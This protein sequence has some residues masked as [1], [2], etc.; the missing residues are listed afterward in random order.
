MRVAVWGTGNMGRAAVRA[1]EAHPELELAGV[2]SRSQPG[3]ADV[4]EGVDAVA[5]M[6]SGDLRPDEAAADIAGCLRGGAVVV[7]PSLYALY[8]VRSAPPALADPLRAAAQ[9]GGGALFVSGID[10]GWGNDVLP[11][12]MSGLASHVEQVRCLIGSR[13]LAGGVVGC[14]GSNC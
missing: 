3:S 10:P 13:R 2:V 5:Y 11:L 12:L 7:T 1:V 8:D 6:A 14:R 4:L 9:E